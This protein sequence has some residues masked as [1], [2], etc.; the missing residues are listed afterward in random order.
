M[1][2]VDGVHRIR[3]ARAPS[4]NGF[5]AEMQS[6]TETGYLW[7]SY[8]IS[9]GWASEALPPLDEAVVRDELRRPSALVCAI[10]CVCVRVVGTGCVII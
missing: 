7:G 8:T 10:S 1:T 9:R 6:T 2:T 3:L 4:G 5:S